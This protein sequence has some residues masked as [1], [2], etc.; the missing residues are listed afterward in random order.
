MKDDAP[1]LEQVG[2]LHLA[3]LKAGFACDL[4]RVGTFQWCSANNHVGF[5]LHPTDTV[6]YKHHPMSHRIGTAHTF[7]ASTLQGL[8][9]TAVFLFNAHTWFFSRHAEAIADWKATLDG[10][11]NPLLDFTCVPF[12]TE[13]A[14]TGHEHTR[15]PAMIIGGKALGFT[16]GRYVTDT[17]SINQFWG[18]IAQGFGHTSVETPFAAP[19]PG[20]W[21]QP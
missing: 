6:P 10:C 15:L 21:S 4:I 17:I 16:H 1:L 7:A 18:T 3:V 8:D 14:A 11:G 9:P 19:V 12:L 20:F 13:T 5:A 2:K